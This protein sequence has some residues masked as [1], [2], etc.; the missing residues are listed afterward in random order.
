M[1]EALL[2]KPDRKFVDEL[3]HE[4]EPGLTDEG[5]RAYL[6]YRHERPDGQITTYEEG[7]IRRFLHRMRDPAKV[8]DPVEQ[9]EHV[10][11]LENFG[12]RRLHLTNF[13]L[14]AAIVLV[15]GYLGLVGLLLYLMF[16]G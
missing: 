14:F 5:L 6:A 13:G 7:Q 8:P 3:Q 9:E 10:G 15:G 1:A 2:L 16:A 4:C 11:R 12:A